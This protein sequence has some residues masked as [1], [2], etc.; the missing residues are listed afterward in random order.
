MKQFLP[1]AWY[2]SAGWLGLLYPLSAL[3]GFLAARNRSAYESGRKPVYRAGVPIIVVG[4]ITAGGTGKTPLT[5]AIAKF[6]Q[7]QGRSPAIITRGY[8]GRS[9]QYPLHVTSTTSVDDCGD[10]ARLLAMNTTVPVVVDPDRSRGVQYIEKNFRPDVILCDDGLQHYALA[11]DVEIAV[12]DGERGFGNG[13]LL[14]AGPLREPRN[15][16]DEVD[17]VVV[18][19][20]LADHTL[21]LGG[22]ASFSMK[23]GV[24]GLIN[25]KSG[26]KKNFAPSEIFEDDI[27][28]KVHA[29]AGI[30]NPERFFRLLQLGGFV[31]MQHVYPDHHRFSKSDIEF[32]DGLPVI[33]TEKDAVKCLDF[34]TAAHWYLKIEAE[35]PAS[36]WHALVAKLD[37]ARNK[38]LAGSPA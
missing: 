13:M 34:A 16:L 27:S 28:A 20:V 25:L 36:F 5:L 17:F 14:P 37:A 31:I 4:N 19:G 10:E 21:Q 6:L 24:D 30:G 2:S 33:M 7:L 29:V 1:R 38:L 8:K 22:K 11:R 35:L 15:R 9:S 3:Y 26:T 32:T 12:I 23:L 18:N